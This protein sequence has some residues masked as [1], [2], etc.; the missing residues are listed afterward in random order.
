M[1][2]YIYIYMPTKGSNFNIIDRQVKQTMDTTIKTCKDITKVCYINKN[3]LHQ[4]IQEMSKK[5][6][7][8][9]RCLK[10]EP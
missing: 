7:V 2:S 10:L 5:Y 8:L 4:E 9:K 3:T 6:Q 1:W